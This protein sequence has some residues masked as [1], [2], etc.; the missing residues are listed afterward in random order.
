[1][2]DSPFRRRLF[3]GFFLAKFDATRDA[4]FVRY[5]RDIGTE[6]QLAL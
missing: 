2:L 3:D 1:M 4:L 6:F 5:G